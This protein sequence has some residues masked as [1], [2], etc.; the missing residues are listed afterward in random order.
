MQAEELVQYL[1]KLRTVRG[2]FVGANASAITCAATLV[3][4]YC[5]NETNK[6]LCG[7]VQKAFADFSLYMLVQ[8]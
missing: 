7:L 1:T 5:N 2:T 3:Q 6:I 8:E 4:I